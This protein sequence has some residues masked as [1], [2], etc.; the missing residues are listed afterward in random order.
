M[1]DEMTRVILASGS[2]RRREFL[3]GLD[4]TFEVIPA[5]IDETP[6]TGE[7]PGDYV[8]RLCA[9]KATH[10][11]KSLSDPAALIIA[12]DTT[13]TFDGRILEK[14]TDDA[15]G[16]AMLRALSGRTHK[17]LT[18][19]AV[20]YSGRTKHALVSTDVEFAALSDADIAWYVGTGEGRDKA[21]GYGLQGR[22][23]VFIKRLNGSVT[24][25]IGLPLPE[26]VELLGEFDVTLTQLRSFNG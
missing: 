24:N 8:S 3:H 10:V 11:A 13:V 26:L 18:G 6:L 15:D 2:P 14:P 20:S 22:A 9:S 19:V 21:G 17:T 23:S 4:L 25:V 7:S 16:I 1:V 12:A 5:D